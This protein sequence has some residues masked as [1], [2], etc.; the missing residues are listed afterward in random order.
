MTTNFDYCL[1]V[2]LHHE[3]GWSNHPLDPGGATNKGITLRTYRRWAKGRLGYVPTKDDLREIPSKHVMTIYRE[4]YWDAVNGLLLPAGVDLMIFDAAVN[5]G[6][7]RAKKILQKAIGVK[8]D[9]IIGPKTLDAL[10]DK[11][12]RAVII[13]IDARRG[14]FYAL[15]KPFSTFGLGWMRRLADVSYRAAVLAETGER[16]P[17]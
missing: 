8:D 7:T 3:G 9:G 14:L 15:L 10:G 11:P 4:N 2:V 13:E 5:K 12:A 16:L 6:P 17:S 1:A